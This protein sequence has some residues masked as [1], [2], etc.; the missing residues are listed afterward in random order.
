MNTSNAEDLV[1]DPDVAVLLKAHGIVHADSAYEFL[2]RY[3]LIQSASLQCR[4]KVP[5]NDIEFWLMEAKIQ[6]S[7]EEL[8]PFRVTEKEVPV[9][10]VKGVEKH[11]KDGC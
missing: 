1:L 4:D 11:S 3:L 6:Q 7:I 5:P 10:F 9:L 8:E 2:Q